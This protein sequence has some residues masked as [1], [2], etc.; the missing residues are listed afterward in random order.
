MIR[1]IIRHINILSS[2]PIHRS[3]REHDKRI[4]RYTGYRP[5]VLCSSRISYRTSIAWR[6]TRVIIASANSP[7]KNI[8]STFFSYLLRI[9]LVYVC[10]SLRIFECR[11]HVCESGAKPARPAVSTLLSDTLETFIIGSPRDSP[12][13]EIH[14]RKQETLVEVAIN[15]RFSFSVWKSSTD[16]NVACDGRTAI[17]KFQTEVGHTN[18][19]T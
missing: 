15:S 16:E 5:R 6:K 2:R 13:S 11:G 18:M 14:E 1:Y 7:A 8:V 10:T 17:Y 9:R 19:I 12:S 4:A 3:E